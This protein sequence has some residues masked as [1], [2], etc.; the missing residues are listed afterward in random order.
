[1]NQNPDD[2]TPV[3]GIAPE[4]AP[5]DATPGDADVPSAAGEAAEGED[6]FIDLADPLT[7]GLPGIALLILVILM[8]GL[9]ISWVVQLRVLFSCRALILSGSGIGSWLRMSQRGGTCG[10]F[11]L[12][13]RGTVR[14]F[15][16]C[17]VC[18]L[19]LVGLILLRL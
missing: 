4:L 3:D 1:M 8:L 19:T 5:L 7:S 18:L 13:R 10:R 16:R 11:T 15:G 17:R 2:L 12:M 9:M 14:L 6:L